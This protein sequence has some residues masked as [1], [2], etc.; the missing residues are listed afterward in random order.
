MPMRMDSNNVPLNAGNLLI[1]DERSEFSVS[2]HAGI[3]W[4]A[5]PDTDPDLLQIRLEIQAE[6][7]IALRQRS[8]SQR[9]VQTLEIAAYKAENSIFSGRLKISRNTS[10]IRSIERKNLHNISALANSRA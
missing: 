2:R 6:T 3:D 9:M 8:L 1:L 10:T 4:Y 7:L 5:L